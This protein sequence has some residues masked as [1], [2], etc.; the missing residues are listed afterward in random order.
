[1]R[2]NLTMELSDAYIQSFIQPR[3]ELLLEMEAF[4]EANHVPIMQLAGID[5]LNQLLR[6]QNPSKI[7]E[8]GTAIGYSAIRMAEA[9]PNVNI[10]TIERDSERV[11]KA[12]DYITRS[13][14]SDRITVI[15]G[16][17]LEVNDQ[18]IHTTFDAVFIDAAKGQYQRFFEKYAPL[19]KSGGVLY[20][21]NMYMH[22][23]SDLNLKDVP[24]RKRTMIRNLKNF[25]EWIMQHPDY[26][27]AFLPVGD[28]L[29]LC[30]K[31]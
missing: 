22:G 2:V 26:T 23:L 7:L 13:T 28:G 16:D 15:E 8:I 12:K 17:A 3:N 10:V 18:A 27:S 14:V 31:R 19:V 6:I 5:A 4:A 30:L 1:M 11:A 24:R 9:L 20:I 29:L 21:D 25:T